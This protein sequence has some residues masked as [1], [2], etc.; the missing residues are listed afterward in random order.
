MKASAELYELV[1]AAAARLRGLLPQT[2]LV[3][4]EWLSAATGAEVRLKLESLQVTGSFKARGALHRL[5]CLD[6]VVR[7]HGVV[8][9]S[10]GNHGL[11]VAH[12]ARRLGCPAQVFVP[13]TTPVEKRIAITQLD[14][15]V[16]AFGDD[17]VQTERHA[18]ALAAASGRTYVSP[19]N[20]PLVAAGQ[21]TVAV[22]LLRQW[23]EVD[24]VYTAVGGGG[25]IGG[26]AGYGRVAA[27]RVE[28]VG[29]SPAASPAMEVC[30]R[31]GRI[32]D[33]SCQETWSDSTAG[34]VEDGAV[35]F[36][37]CRDLV[38]R[39]LQVDEASIAAALRETLARQQ[40]LV[41]GA[42]AV[43]I[44][45]LLADRSARGRR[46]AIV[47]CG[48]NLPLAKLRALL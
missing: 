35:T 31:Q 16:V 2:P 23:P 26:M 11:G 30:V 36:D 7:A 25:L 9:A 28:W 39:W 43:P 27:P 1:L 6:D 8:A 38:A 19:Y 24:A 33:V 3:A 20:D 47:V 46:I 48:A 37:Y 5:L 44:A 34:G 10:S 18:R 22:E 40:L 32:V 29:C 12:A 4:S 42:A 45:A 17:C 21:G 15:E 41:E 13:T 14:A